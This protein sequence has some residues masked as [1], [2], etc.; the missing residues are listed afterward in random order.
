MMKQKTI[1]LSEDAY[2]KLR[3][4]KGQKESFSEVILRVCQQLAESSEEPLNEFVGSLAGATEFLDDIDLA[5]RKSR[6]AHLVDESD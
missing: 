3:A 1:S 5:I 6:E 4:L 2:R